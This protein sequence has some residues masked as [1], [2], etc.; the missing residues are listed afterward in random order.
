L[1]FTTEY[2]SSWEHFVVHYRV[3][4]VVET[5]WRSLPSI[6][7]RGNILSFTTE[8][9]SSWR[10]FGVHYRV[11]IVVETFWRYYRVS[12]V[13]K[14]SCRSLPSINCRGDILSFITEYQSSRRQFGVHYRV[15]IVVGTFWRSLPNINRRENTLS[16]TTEYQSSR[17]HFGVHYRVPIVVET[18]CRS[19]S[20]LLTEWVN[21][22]MLPVVTELNPYI[23]LPELRLRQ[24]NK[25]RVTVLVINEISNN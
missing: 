7:R 24:N 12:I 10:H 13:V 18:F 3:S 21:S 20:I 8:Y 17:R 22:T 25:G 16:F 9:Q 11:P 2:Q 1:S 14:T 4:I 23:L 5:F 19:L 15:S 6:N